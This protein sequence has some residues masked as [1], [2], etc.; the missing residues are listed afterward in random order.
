MNFIFVL[1]VC[2]LLQV[3]TKTLFDINRINHCFLL[4]CLKYDT[5]RYDTL[6][7]QKTITAQ[8]HINKYKYIYIQSSKLHTEQYHL[9][10]I[11]VRNVLQHISVLGKVL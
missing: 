4:R 9:Y 8:Q 1:F 7:M 6:L 11:Y 5:I 2:V 10:K 3:E